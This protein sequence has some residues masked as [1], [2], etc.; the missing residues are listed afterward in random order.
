[1]D[2]FWTRSC[3][4]IRICYRNPQH[5]RFFFCC[6][7]LILFLILT[8]LMSFVL[9]ADGEFSFIAHTPSSMQCCVFC[10]VCSSNWKLHFENNAIFLALHPISSCWCQ[11]LPFMNHDQKYT[12]IFRTISGDIENCANG[13]NKWVYRMV[14]VAL[15]LSYCFTI[16]LQFFVDC[17]IAHSSSLFSFIFHVLYSSDE[18]EI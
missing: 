6:L 12:K 13:T 11:M 5:R 15:G 17:T 14:N 10:F 8:A 9:S 16:T 1:M 2:A 3:L 18:H 7:T 4:A